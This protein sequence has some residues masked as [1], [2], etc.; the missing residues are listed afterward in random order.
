MPYL[1]PT[2]YLSPTPYLPLQ[3]TCR[4]VPCSVPHAA[5]SSHRFALLP[6]SSSLSGGSREKFLFLRSR[7]SL[8]DI[9]HHNDVPHSSPHVKF[10]SR[11]LTA[12]L[13]LSPIN[14]LY[15]R[16]L[17]GLRRQWK[18]TPVAP[19]TPVRSSQAVEGAD[20]LPLPRPV[21]KPLALTTT[22]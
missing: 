6:M 16:L 22:L 7:I 18:V 14:N 17:R 12:L 10:H 19:V 2:Q 8:S 4:R 9:C 21:A 20:A 1:S 3:A 15:W 11:Y 5:L 13:M